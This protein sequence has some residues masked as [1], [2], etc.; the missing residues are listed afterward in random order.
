MNMRWIINFTLMVI[1]FGIIFGLLAGGLNPWK[2]PA[3][4]NRI[5]ME[6]AHQQK[7]YALQ[8]QLAQAKTEADVQAIRREQEMLEAQYVHDKQI[9]AQDVV[10]Q[11]R[12]NEALV[13]LLVWF[14]GAL[15]I[16]VMAL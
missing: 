13:T 5:N 16:G 12:L 1:V 15:S 3:E 4:A 2:G 11:Q 6:T 10:H 7:L 9:L 8:E 14:G